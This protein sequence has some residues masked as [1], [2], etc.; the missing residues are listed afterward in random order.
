M[1]VE[2]IGLIL[3]NF[4]HVVAPFWGKRKRIHYIR[5]VIRTVRKV[6]FMR[7]QLVL[8]SKERDICESIRSFL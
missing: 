2:R 7:R 6:A 5:G 1:I 8:L 3:L 4:A